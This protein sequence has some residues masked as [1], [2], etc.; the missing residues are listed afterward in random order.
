MKHASSVFNNPGGRN[1]NTF[2]AGEKTE[3]A[4]QLNNSPKAT[5]IVVLAEGDRTRVTA[6]FQSRAHQSAL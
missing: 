1:P 3:A 5:G 6:I 2:F 4:G